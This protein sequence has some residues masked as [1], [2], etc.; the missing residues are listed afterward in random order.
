[1]PNL[2]DSIKKPYEIIDEVAQIRFSNEPVNALNRRTRSV[3]AQLLQAA[4]NDA[5]VKAIVLEGGGNHFSAGADIHEIGTN[6]AMAAPNVPDLIAMIESSEKPV[7]A[8]IRGACMGGGLELALGCHYRI[9]A[10]DVRFALP[11]AKLGVIPGAGG[12]QRLPR[13]LGVET[14]LNMILSGRVVDSDFCRGVPGQALV[15]RFA[16]SSQSLTEEATELARDAV[17]RGGAL[18]AIRKLPCVHPHGDAYFQFVRNNVAAQSRNAPALLQCIE[19][20]QAATRLTFDAGLAKEREI[21]LALSKTPES[22]ALRHLFLAERAAG[23]VEGLTG[24]PA[25]G[26]VKTIGVVGAGTMGV[27]IAIN[28]L[29]ADIP[30]AVLEMSQE[31]LD[32]GVARFQTYYGTQVAKGRLSQAQADERLSLLRPS[33]S[34]DDLKDCDLIIEAVFEDMA[35]KKGVFE[36]LEKVAKPGAILATNTS[37]LDVNELAAHTGRPQ[38]VVGL[39]FFSPA[40]VMK[41][42][43]VVRAAA[44]SSETLATALHLT[45]RIKKIAVVSGVCDG[46]IG[47]RMLEQYLRQAEFMLDEGAS[48]QQVDKAIEAF[49]FAMGPFRMLDLAG[50]DINWAIRKRRLA[51]HPDIKYSPMAAKLCEMGRFGQKVGAGWYDYKPGKRQPLPSDEVARLIDAERK[52]MGMTPRRISDG[53]IVRRLVY[54]LINE[55]ARVL[56]EGIASKASDIDIAYVMG[57]GFPAF[58][59]GPMH[60]AG[61]VTLSRIL[62]EIGEF[63]KKHGDSQFWQPAAL[64]EKLVAEG[65]TGFASTAN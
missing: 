60:Y 58:R 19:A 56:E 30:V 13:A 35:V 16:E 26:D 1:M 40:N 51:D 9:V 43:E 41:L 32:R 61:H 59:G 7:I 57:Y 29:N 37:T 48:P 8:A 6:E 3:L 15:D 31:A 25:S 10:P 44:T 46:F 28:F 52:A 42:V 55:G 64:I 34:Y 62:Y 14:A 11:E 21:F 33:L 18:P 23:K 54:A 53:E 5:E 47:N 24:E 63:S 4:L 39:H 49:G 27:G 12:T 38:D 17:V 36:Q 22:S 45:K 2:T 50:G 20:V 65:K